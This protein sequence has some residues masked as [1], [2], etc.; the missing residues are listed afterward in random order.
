MID[1]LNLEPTKVSRDLKGKYICIYSI[2]KAGKTSF[3]AS[4]PKNLILGFEHGW[5]ALPGVKAVDITRWADLKLIL[6]QL[7]TDEA[8]AMYDTIT[9]DTVGLMWELCEKYICARNNVSEIGDVP[10]G[11]GWAQWKKEFSDCLR[12]IVQMG[13][14]LVVIAHST[15]RKEKLSNDSEIEILAPNIPNRAY[16]IVNQLVD[17][18]AYIDVEWD[19]DGN[20]RRTLITRK[21]PTVMAGSRYKYLPDKIPFGYEEL[22][23]AI[24]DAVDKLE[25]EK[26]G[27]VTEEKVTFT[28][29]SESESMS[30][31]D[32][33]EEAQ[34]LWKSIVGNDEAKAKEILKITEK[35]FGVPTRLSSI[36]PEQKDLFYL[37]LVEMR[38][39]ANKQK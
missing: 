7:N 23:N 11:Q 10:W 17:I 19:A 5:N 6:R 3:S 38:D 21:T 27:S 4:F 8:K 9:I 39:L 36:T 13:Y 15:V 26:A 1:I 14:G 31:E 28:E 35:I 2:P 24:A 18:I 32:I 12:S 33:T 29:D 37:V 30:F 34:A 16:D 22:T 20:S 25:Q